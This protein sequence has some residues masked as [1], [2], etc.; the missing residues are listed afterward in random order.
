MVKLAIYIFTIITF[1]SCSLSQKIKDG[2]TAY[3][4]KQYAVAKEMLED[5]YDESSNDKVK[6][7][8]AYLLGRTYFY[9]KN[10]K[11]SVEWLE[12]A[13]V[14]N[15]GNDAIRDLAYGYKSLG[16]YTKAIQTFELLIQNVGSRAE[17]SREIAICKE[18]INWSKKQSEEYTVQKSYVNSVQAEYAPVMYEGDYVVFT[19]DRGIS[20]GSERYNWTG[21]NFSHT[22]S[23]NISSILLLL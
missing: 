4:R 3:E 12:K 20:S 15:H 10:D 19:S 7:R 11:F 17:I 2:D 1:I 5:E 18:A 16:Q 6:A 13:V 21:N 8:K 23:L 9:L 14:R 22:S